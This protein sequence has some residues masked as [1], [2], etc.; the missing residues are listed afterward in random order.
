MPRFSHAQEQCPPSWQGGEE[1]HPW[2]RKVRG[3]MRYLPLLID[4]DNIYCELLYLIAL[5]LIHHVQ[6]CT[7]MRNRFLNPIYDCPNTTGSKGTKFWSAWTRD[8]RWSLKL[9][10]TPL[11][12]NFSTWKIGPRGPKFGISYTNINKTIYKVLTLLFY[13]G[14]RSNTPPHPKKNLKG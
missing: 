1:E 11:A 10:Y 13:E 3:R 12:T 8:L 5:F 2:K 4:L 9:L 7:S 6:M 14:G